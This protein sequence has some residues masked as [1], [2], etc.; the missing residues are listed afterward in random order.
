VYQSD[1]RHTGT[2]LHRHTGSITELLDDLIF[3][4]PIQWATAIAFPETATHSIDFGPG[5]L[6][7]IGLFTARNYKVVGCASLSSATREGDV[8]LYNARH[9][10]YED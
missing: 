3:T 4:L 1:L 7:G 6:S 9:V 10:R 8:E 2:D 5:G